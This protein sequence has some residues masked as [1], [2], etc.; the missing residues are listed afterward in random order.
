MKKSISDSTFVTASAIGLDLSDRKGNW[1]AIDSRGTQIGS[2]VVA[3]T[4]TAL[5]AWASRFQPTVISIEAGGNSAW[6]SRTLMGVGHEVIVANPVKVALITKNIGKGDEVDAEYLARL[7][8]FD[9]RLLHEV[10]H[11]GEQAQSDLQMIRSRDILVRTRTKLITHVR[12]AVKSFGYRLPGSSGHSF[13]KLAKL[14]MP[15]LLRSAL[16]PIVALIEQ[17]T[18]KI[19]AYDQDV[20]QLVEDRYPEAKRLMQVGGVGA[21]TATTFVLVLE[22]V[23]RFTQ[24]RAVGAYLGLTPRRD[25][26]GASDPQRG[27]T[28]A[29]DELLRRLLVQGSQYILG[30]FGPDCDL[31]RHGEKISKGGGQKAKRRAVVAIARK[32]AVLLHHLWS[33]GERYQPLFNNTI[34]IAA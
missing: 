23:K 17:L 22:D 4:V 20:E 15:E 6:V 32:L 29:G 30:P 5:R 25:Q 16:D 10:H 28:G 11:R 8:R 3:L 18:I 33:T 31:K 26:S 34:N 12:G 27:I 9:R 7:A 14:H 1:Y 2:G 13:H 19:R 24:S 21:L